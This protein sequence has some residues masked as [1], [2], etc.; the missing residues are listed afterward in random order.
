MGA[1]NARERE[2]DVEDTRSVNSPRRVLS[3]STKG[4]EVCPFRSLATRLPGLGRLGI[5]DHGPKPSEVYG[6]VGAISNVAAAG[7]YTSPQSRG[8]LPMH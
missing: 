4:G 8:R 5:R 7:I 3:L 6:F 2:R 1:W